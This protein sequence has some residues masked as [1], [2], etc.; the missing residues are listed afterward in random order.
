MPILGEGA[1]AAESA[2]WARPRAQAGRNG[3]HDAIKVREVLI[4]QTA[5]TNQFPNPLNRIELRTIRR[6]E[7]EMEMIGD[8]LAPRR[9]EAGMMIAGIVANDDD[10]AVRFTA[11]ALQ[12]AQ[13]IPT[14]ARI[15]HP[16]RSRHHQLAVTEANR[17]KEADAFAR[18]CVTADRIDDLWRHPQTAA[19]AV[20]LKMDFI[21]GPQINLGFS[22]QAT[23]FF[24][25]LFAG[26]GRLELPAGEVCATESPVAETSA[27][28][29]AP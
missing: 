14:G 19:R 15:E 23:E 27:G 11:A 3:S 9:M 21:H 24:Y 2:V 18:R 7:V 28:T 26:R 20:L 8:A 10:L 22:S 16:V 13:E 29:A 4:M 6:Q 25:A 5:A 1:Q 17:T 12:F